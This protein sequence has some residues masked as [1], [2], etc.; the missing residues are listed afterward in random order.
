MQQEISL[1]IDLHE[2]RKVDLE[3][4]AR[5]ALAF[6]MLVKEV[7]FAIEPFVEVRIELESGTEGSLSLNSVI[8]SVRLDKARLRAIAWAVAAFFVADTTSYTYQAILDRILSEPEVRETI[9]KEQ[10]EAIAHEVAKVIESK[11]ADKQASKVYQELQRD[12]AVRGVGVSPNRDRRPSDVV[13]RSEFQ[14]R[15]RIIQESESTGSRSETTI[16]TVTLVSPVLVHGST[17]QWKFKQGK[18]EFGAPI[19]D[20]KFLA[21]VLSG[22]EPVPMADGITMKVVLTVKEERKDGVWQVKSRT[23]DEVMEITPPAEP[24]DLFGSSGKG[25]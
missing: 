17:R 23:I 1:Y 4:A 6:D 7:A 22:R 20:E 11:I 9:T 25:E 16:Q 21:R 13:P 2:G 8:S 10:I 18:N 15:G 24:E 5:S 19:K 12:D 14:K 3:T